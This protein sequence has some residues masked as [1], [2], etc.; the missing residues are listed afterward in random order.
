MELTIGIVISGIGVVMTA[1]TLGGAIVYKYGRLNKSSDKHESDIVEIFAR[2]RGLETVVPAL[3]DVTNRLEA[4]FANGIN[5]KV[6][7]LAVDVASIKQHCQDM[8]TAAPRER[9]LSH[10]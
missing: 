4:L 8:H 5:S 6:Q 1:A 3:R 10:P 2:L 9:K 7:A